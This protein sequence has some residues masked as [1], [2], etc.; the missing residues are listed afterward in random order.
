M[1]SRN[2]II[3]IM[4]DYDFPSDQ[5]WIAAS[6]GLVLHGVKA[7]A[8]DV[9][10]GCTSQL[11]D[12]L[13]ASK[14]GIAFEKCGNRAYKLNGHLEV[15]EN[16]EADSVFV[17]EGLPVASLDSIKKHKLELGRDKDILDVAAIDSFLKDQKL[18]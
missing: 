1:L 18:L 12:K 16:W 9:D 15:F 3:R 2:D 11:M 10:I 17:I 6:A 14:A 7:V 5:Y 13:Y 4:Q 8:G